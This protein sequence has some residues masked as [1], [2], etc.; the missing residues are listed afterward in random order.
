MAVFCGSEGAGAVPTSRVVDRQGSALR[1][2]LGLVLLSRLSRVKQ[3]WQMNP[4]AVVGAQL[5]PPVPLGPPV[6]AFLSAIRPSIRNG[7][8]YRQPVAS[9]ITYFRTIEIAEAVSLAEA[10]GSS[11]TVDCGFLEYHC[12]C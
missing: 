6:H 11:G 3:S 1:A 7:R 4:A 12:R 5:E 8:V 9:A 2:L 10:L